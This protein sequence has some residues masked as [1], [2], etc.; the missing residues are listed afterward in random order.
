MAYK[1]EFSVMAR[2]YNASDRRTRRVASG[3]SNVELGKE[4]ERMAV[5]AEMR[6]HYSG[7]PLTLDCRDSFKISF[8]RID[9]SKGHTLDNMVVTSKLMNL[10]RNDTPYDQW[11]AEAQWVGGRLL[12]MAQG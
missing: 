2:D 1:S 6:C 8:D 12:E 9:N 10:L 3:L 11:V 5:E 7:I 4:L